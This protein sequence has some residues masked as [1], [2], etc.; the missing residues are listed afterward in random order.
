MLA[1]KSVKIVSRDNRGRVSLSKFTDHDM[2]MIDVAEDGTITMTPMIAMPQKISEK[3][4]EFLDE[5]SAGVRVT[6]PGMR[7]GEILNRAS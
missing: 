1:T 5:P 3:I 4:D 2:F 7:Y 6:R